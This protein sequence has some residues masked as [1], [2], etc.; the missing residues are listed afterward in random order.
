[1]QNNPAAP[2]NTV[3]ENTRSVVVEKPRRKIHWAQPPPSPHHY[4]NPA[5]SAAVSPPIL[6]PGHEVDEDR[7]FY[8]VHI[9]PYKPAPVEER[10]AGG[11]RVHNRLDNVTDYNLRGTCGWEHAHEERSQRLEK[12]VGRIT[13][14]SW[15]DRRLWRVI[16]PVQRKDPDVGERA[17]A[18]ETME[19]SWKDEHETRGTRN[20][21]D[22]NER[23]TRNYLLRLQ[24]RATTKA[25]DKEPKADVCPDVDVAG[26][27]EGTQSLPVVFQ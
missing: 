11:D 21:S 23:G 13:M 9:A 25:K 26:Q 17:H 27:V 6:I 7:S 8:A 2:S 4:P 5:S 19:E 1:M 20:Y 3:M 22:M 15:L 24:A 18:I 14:G 12:E 10:N 16:R